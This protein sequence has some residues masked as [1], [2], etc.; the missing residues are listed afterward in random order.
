MLGCFDKK[1]RAG[2]IAI[3]KC[4]RAEKWRRKSQKMVRMTERF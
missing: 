4:R 2:F 3:P 1:I